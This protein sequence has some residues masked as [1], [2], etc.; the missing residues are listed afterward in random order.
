MKPRKAWVV[1]IET[2]R[3]SY[4][5]DVLPSAWG[6]TKI[7]EYL[8][9]MHRVSA[10][11]LSEQLATFRRKAP[12]VP[13]RARQRGGRIVYIM[14]YS[15]MLCAQYSTVLEIHTVNERDWIRYLPEPYK[16]YREDPQTHAL[17][18]AETVEPEE[19]HQQQLDLSWAR[20][21]PETTR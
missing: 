20:L 13:E 16:V 8:E 21:V 5:L 18:V 14:I 7:G 3:G 11:S 10:L 19:R 2:T 12:F 9:T 6:T 4:A 15:D 17:Y 1:S